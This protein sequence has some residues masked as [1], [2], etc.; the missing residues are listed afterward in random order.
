MEKL[1]ERPDR[2]QAGNRDQLAYMLRDIL[3]LALRNTDNHG[4]NAAVLRTGG[5]VGLSPIF[6]FAPM[7]LDPEGPGRGDRRTP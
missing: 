5:Q 1:E 4:R 3:N 2:R 7:F 6:D